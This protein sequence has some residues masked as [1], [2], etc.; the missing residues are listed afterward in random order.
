VDKRFQKKI[1]DDLSRRCAQRFG[2]EALQ[3]S[4]SEAAGS[5]EVFDLECE[6][7]KLLRFTARF[8]AL[9]D[10]DLPDSGRFGF[11]RR[12][13]TDGRF[14]IGAGAGEHASA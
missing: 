11:Q 14:L 7:G 2:R 12:A 10:F 5:L 1:T 3:Q 4:G 9:P 13:K 6:K 8:L